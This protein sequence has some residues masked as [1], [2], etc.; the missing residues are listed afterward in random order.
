M[1]EEVM[2]NLYYVRITDIKNEEK[3]YPGQNI[4][5]DTDKLITVRNFDIYLV[6]PSTVNFNISPAPKSTHISQRTHNNMSEYEVN[7][8]LLQVTIDDR[9]LILDLRKE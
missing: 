3:K 5:L 9:A 4:V 2:T 6:N 1:P 7:E 8:S